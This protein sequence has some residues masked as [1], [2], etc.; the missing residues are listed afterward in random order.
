LPDELRAHLRGMED[1]R[2]H[3]AC[4][5]WALRYG[6]ALGTLVFYGYRPC[7]RRESVED[8]WLCRLAEAVARAAVV[9]GP[10]WAL[11]V[12]YQEGWRYLEPPD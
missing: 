4:D 2:A 5:V 6:Q 10:T 3:D 7:A 11:Q 1:A 9:F 8:P 12:A